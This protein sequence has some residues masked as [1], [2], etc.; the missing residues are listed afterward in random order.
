MTDPNLTHFALALAR[1]WLGIMIFAHGWRHL[2]ATRSGPGIAN[3]FESLGLLPGPLHAWNVT[4]TELVVGVVLVAGF[5]TPLAYGGLCSLLLVAA[6][7]NHRKNGFFINNP[8]EGWE[9][10]VTVAVLAIALGTLGPGNWSL[11]HAVGFS[12]PFQNGT[13]LLITALLG[14]GGTAAFLAVFWRPRVEQPS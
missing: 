1:V 9:Y 6:V 11:D 2:A 12:F 7:T 14:L 13:A 4:V 5:L 3:W 10:V 8:G